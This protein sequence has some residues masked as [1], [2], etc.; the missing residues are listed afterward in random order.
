MQAMID[1]YNVI[2]MSS[3]KSNNIVR[4]VLKEII[5]EPPSSTRKSYEIE[6]LKL[7]EA[8]TYL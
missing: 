2:V 4:Q 3:Q 1:V 6:Q 8:V 7:A 5:S